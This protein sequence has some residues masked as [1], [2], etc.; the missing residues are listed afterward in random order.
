MF[1]KGKEIPSATN[2]RNFIEMLSWSV[3]LSLV[4]FY[5]ILLTSFC[6]EGCIGKESSSLCVDSSFINDVNSSLLL[7]VLPVNFVAR[8][9]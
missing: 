1:V 9:L 2:F 4:T 6:V 5:R 7:L 3:E 8:V